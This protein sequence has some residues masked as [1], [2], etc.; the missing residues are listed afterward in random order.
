MI[1]I[2]RRTC[3]TTHAWLRGQEK[4]NLSPCLKKCEFLPTSSSIFSFFKNNFLETVGTGGIVFTLRLKMADWEVIRV[5]K[6]FSPIT[7]LPGRLYR[8]IYLP[9]IYSNLRGLWFICPDNNSLYFW[10]GNL[11]DHPFTE[12]FHLF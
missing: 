8:L 2:F 3:A 9:A 5:Q 10:K 1:P 12:V 7:C 6:I 4:S 11:N